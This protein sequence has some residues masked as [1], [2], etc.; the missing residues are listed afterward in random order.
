MTFDSH[1]IARLKQV[2]STKPRCII[3]LHARPDGDTIGASLALYEGLKNLQFPV[4]VACRD[5][6]SEKYSFLPLT[7]EVLSF[8]QPE[9]YEAV[10]FVDSAE[11]KMTQFHETYPRILSDDIFK[12]NIDHHPSNDSFG[13]VNF[14]V[15]T[16]AS[17][18]QI[19]FSLLQ[20]L[21]IRITPSMA[22]A[23][24]LGLYTDTGAF[25]HQNTSSESY[26]VASRLVKLGAD[27]MKISKNMF[28]SYDL[29]TLK[30][31]GKVLQNLYVTASGAAIVGIS[32]KD[33][34]SLGCTKE[35]LEGVV[36]FINSMPDAQYA[37]LLSE[38]EKGNVKASL[39][40]RKN[41][42]D[43][44]A[45][46]QKFGGGGHVKAS[47]FTVK[48]GHLEKDIKWKIVQE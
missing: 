5:A 33:Y 41:D 10:F 8:F 26:E 9:V 2:L 1:E 21:G 22:T 25:M 35:D 40:T 11:R 27:Y 29:K 16:A 20:T 15:P 42:I 18:S 44:K 39:R 48:G 4:H 12:I 17:S 31:W 24:L 19:M 38:D 32:R 34:E 30:L 43:V 47:G 7:T 13:N 46:A 3:L 14:V 37:V 45:L 6:I 23:L 28:Q 36:N